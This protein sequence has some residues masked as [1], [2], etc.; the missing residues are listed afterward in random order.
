MKT[1]SL[2]KIALTLALSAS[3]FAS[4]GAIINSDPKTQALITNQTAQD[5]RHALERAIQ[6][7]AQLAQDAGLAAMQILSDQMLTAGSLVQEAQT[8]VYLANQE[9]RREFV[10][11]DACGT[12]T[13]GLQLVNNACAVD[14]SRGEE[15]AATT[16][17]SI[18][19][20]ETA[21]DL[22]KEGVSSAAVDRAAESNRLEQQEL[23][24][25]QC[26]G[27]IVDPDRNAQV[28]ERTDGAGRAVI[29]VPCA[30][31]GTLIPNTHITQAESEAIS[32]TLEMM[33][34]VTRDRLNI[35]VWNT[36]KDALQDDLMTLS[37]KHLAHEAMNYVLSLKRPPDAG[38]G[39]SQ[40]DTLS[41]HIK[42]NIFGGT[43]AANIID[44]AT[45][46]S[47][48]VATKDIALLMRTQIYLQ[49]LQYE[50]NLR[51]EVLTAAILESQL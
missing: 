18:A 47:S 2:T 13:T 22:L 5:A 41:D 31:L 21:A 4:F 25:E 1:K 9:A 35:A 26:L 28:G 51:S 11:N 39:Q 48:N 27:E 46:E 42:T 23:L 8:D 17:P 34:G 33:F 19:T 36:D 32:K 37:R 30:R 3:S 43:E 20:V 40:L 15:R 10:P 44:L 14:E 49:Y 24:L 38:R 7:G 16:E 6:A 12:I 45:T 50:S 29:T